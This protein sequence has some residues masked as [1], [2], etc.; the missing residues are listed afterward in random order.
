LIFN[1]ILAKDT[2]LSDGVTTIEDAI[3]NAKPQGYDDFVKSVN[4]SIKAINNT[5]NN[6]VVLKTFLFT[7]YEESEGVISYLIKNDYLPTLKSGN[8]ITISEINAKNKTIEINTDN[9][10]FTFG[11]NK[12]LQ[13]KIIDGGIF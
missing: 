9:E 4:E 1:G 7:T 11:E 12:E 13:I 3:S 6:D 5:L 10:T 8:G 2:K